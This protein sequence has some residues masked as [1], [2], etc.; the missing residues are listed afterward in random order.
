MSEHPSG[1]W[2]RRPSVL[3]LWPWT[4]TVLAEDEDGGTQ[5]SLSV[6]PEDQKKL[7]CILSRF[8]GAW[9]A[10]ILPGRSRP[11]HM[12]WERSPLGCDMSLP[13][14]WDHSVCR[15]T[16]LGERTPPPEGGR[17]SLSCRPNLEHH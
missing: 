3:V 17:K 2:Q 12:G 11:G 1:L 5:L 10:V 6:A 14:L 15:L 9:L 13:G 7:V 8:P 16:R 4:Q